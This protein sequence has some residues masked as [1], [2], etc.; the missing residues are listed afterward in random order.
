MAPPRAP[1]STSKG[2]KTLRN[3]GRWLYAQRQ[4]AIG[5]AWAK[6]KSDRNS[7]GEPIGKFNQWRKNNPQCDKIMKEFSNAGNVAQLR[8]N[9]I[10]DINNDPATTAQAINYFQENLINGSSTPGVDKFVPIDPYLSSIDGGDPQ[11]TAGIREN[12]AEI[13]NWLE[14]WTQEGLDTNIEKPGLRFDRDKAH[15]FG[16]QEPQPGPS[17]V[18]Q[19]T[20]TLEAPDDDNRGVKRPSTGGSE[21]PEDTQIVAPSPAKGQGIEEAAAGPSNAKIPKMATPVADPN[22]AVIAGRAGIGGSSTSQAVGNRSSATSSEGYIRIPRSIPFDPPSLTFRNSH[23]FYSYGYANVDVIKNNG[24]IVTSTP[25][26]Y[27]PVDYIPLYL[28]NAEFSRLPIG[29]KVKRVGV[30][31]TCLGTRTSFDTG[32]SISGVATSEYV[33]IGMSVTG[34]NNKVSMKNYMYESAATN[35]MLP[36]GAKNIDEAQIVQRLWS[37]AESM[38]HCVPR[39]L[40]YYA[41]LHESQ[42]TRGTSTGPQYGFPLGR[43]RLDKFVDRHLVSSGIGQQIAHYSYH[44]KRGYIRTPLPHMPAGISTM[45]STNANT[46]TAGTMTAIYGDIMRT[47]PGVLRITPVVSKRSEQT[48]G[49]DK[50]APSISDGDI[51]NSRLR[52]TNPQDVDYYQATIERISCWKGDSGRQSIH[53]QPQLHVGLVA[54]P[55][56]NPTTASTNYLN[57]SAYWQIDTVMEVEINFNSITENSPSVQ[58]DNAV[59]TDNIGG[60][61]FGIN[62][63]GL[64]AKD[65]IQSSFNMVRPSAYGDSDSSVVNNSVTQVLGNDVNEYEML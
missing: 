5:E 20:R 42:L 57:A 47:Q 54:I 15:W 18:T 49:T 45:P 12:Q 34:L 33:G 64:N 41:C 26:A 48:G 7:A 1:T 61:P 43:Y 3:F 25:L 11:T 30:T 55:Q 56:L 58:A 4:R 16:Q 39:Q 38:A 44:P 63:Y 46:T 51:N 17:G 52:T 35:P 50:N 21:V 19:P 36:T 23:I 40:P 13:E 28:T 65:N 10:S 14:K 53:A 32:T 22:N 27:I 2:P 59:F 37:D 6:Y 9:F 24:L 60:L 29:T 62:P 31:V 8:Q